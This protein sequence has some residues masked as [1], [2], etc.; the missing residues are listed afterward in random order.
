[1]G[2]MK[3]IEI[4][5]A[6]SAE[7]SYPWIQCSISNHLRKSLLKIALWHSNPLPNL[8]GD[9]WLDPLIIQQ[10]KQ[11]YYSQTDIAY[12]LNVSQ[13]SIHARMRRDPKFK[14]QYYFILAN[15]AREIGGK[16]K[17]LTFVYRARQR[18]IKTDKF[19]PH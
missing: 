3:Q 6:M 14:K 2:G 5:A 15:D 17:S 16:D 13:S 12:K 8:P 11:G 10:M 9:H 19:L 18:K 1:M 7:Q 4:T